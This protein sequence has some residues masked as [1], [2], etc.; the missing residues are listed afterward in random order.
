[1]FNIIISINR[2][3]KEH[4]KCFVWQI[5]ERMASDLEAGHFWTRVRLRFEFQVGH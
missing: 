1:M 4:I 2:K 5:S 3:S